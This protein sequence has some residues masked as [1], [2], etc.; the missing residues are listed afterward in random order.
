MHCRCFGG[1]A[2]RAAINTPVQGTAADMIKL[3]MINIQGL[4]DMVVSDAIVP[5][6]QRELKHPLP[7]ELEALCMRCLN[8]KPEG[9]FANGSE[10]AAALDSVEEM[11][12]SAEALE[13][14]GTWV[15]MDRYLAFAATEIW[16]GHWDGYAWTRN[17][18][19]LYR[20]ERNEPRWTWL[21]WGLDQTLFEHLPPLGGDGR[22]TLLC[23]QHA[24]C[25][26]QLAQHF[27]EVSARAAALD[28]MAATFT[29]ESQLWDKMVEHKLI[30]GGLQ[31]LLSVVPLP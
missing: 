25:R 14:L 1:A 13:A 19:F 30:T 8:K 10:L 27:K 23:N 26:A 18:Y 16:L 6:S 29:L 24:Y 7:P 21:P 15:D 11:D 2:T 12:D 31:Q 9:R 5:I 4:L 28:L 20:P 17:N 22:V 3:A